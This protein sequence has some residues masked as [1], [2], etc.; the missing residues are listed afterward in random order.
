MPMTERGGARHHPPR[1]AV[2]P[3]AAVETSGHVVPRNV[4]HD[5]IPVSGQRAGHRGGCPLQTNMAAAMLTC[6]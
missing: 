4:E 1:H 2:H 6:T 3:I 5:V